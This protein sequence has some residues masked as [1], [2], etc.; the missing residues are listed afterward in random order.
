MRKLILLLTIFLTIISCSNKIENKEENNVKK[1]KFE[2]VTGKIELLMYG[3]CSDAKNCTTCE[4]YNIIL[5]K[6]LEYEGKYITGLSIDQFESAV[7]DLYKYSDIKVKVTG[8]INRE[9][10]IIILEKVEIID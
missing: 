8:Y 3:C 2:T 1:E 7:E 5:D 6:R 10:K 9:E 4:E